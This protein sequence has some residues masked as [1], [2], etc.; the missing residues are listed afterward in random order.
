MTQDETWFAKC[1][2]VIIFIESNHRNPSMHNATERYQYGNWVKHNRKLMN[3]GKMK[4]ERV[5]RFK[6]L[7]A[8]VEKY[9]HVNQ[10]Q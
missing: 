4:E 1:Q 6:I 10:Y 7:L 3:A 8:L 9:R 2:E 5:I